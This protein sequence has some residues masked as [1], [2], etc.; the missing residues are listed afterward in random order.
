[1]TVK[2]NAVPGVAVPGAETEKCVAAAALTVIVAE[3]PV[4]EPFTVSVAVIVCGP[5]VF[6]VAENVPVP[7][8][9]AEFAGNTAAPSLLVK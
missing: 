7:F 1:V 3:V 6:S 4:I 9:S 5:L 8:V 2:F